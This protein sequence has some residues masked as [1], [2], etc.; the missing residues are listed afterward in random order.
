MKSLLILFSVLFYFN[1]FSQVEK[2]KIRAGFD[3]F[4]YYPDSTIKAAHRYTGV[5]LERFVVEFNATGMPVAMGKMKK[6][7]KSG[8][9]IYSDGSCDVFDEK[10]PG[11]WNYN[12]K[13]ASSGSMRPGCGTGIFQAKKEFNDTYQELLK[14]QSE[15][16]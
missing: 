14:P 16:R 6:G 9:W 2:E 12:S 11:L 7:K 8:K 15:I 3:Y 10:S 4:E 5:S 13:T 1:G